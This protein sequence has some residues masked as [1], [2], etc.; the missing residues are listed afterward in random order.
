M[1]INNSLLKILGLTLTLSF[2][3]CSTIEGIGKDVQ[4][5]GR[6]IEKTSSSV[7]GKSSTTPLTPLENNQPATS[8]AVVTPV[9]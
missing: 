3:S 6:V 1:K 8:G 9:R 2:T 5:L 4:G 7:S